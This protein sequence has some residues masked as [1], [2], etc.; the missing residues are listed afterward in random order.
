MDSGP[1]IYSPHISTYF[2]HFQAVD[3]VYFNGGNK[4]GYY[5]VFATARRHKGLVQTL[6]FIRVSNHNGLVHSHKTI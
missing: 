5:C 3:A 6:L 1:F 4:E 2:L